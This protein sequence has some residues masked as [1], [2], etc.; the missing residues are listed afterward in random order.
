M[1]KPRFY[2]CMG[3]HTSGQAEAVG[4]EN[5][6]ELFLNSVTVDS[7]KTE[8]EDWICALV[9]NDTITPVK[10]DTGAQVNIL[11]KEDYRQLRDRTETLKGYNHSKI[12]VKGLCVVTVK[13]RGHKYKLEFFVV[14]ALALPLP[15]NNACE[16]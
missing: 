15:T 11:S 7:V 13:R 6:D 3:N 12:P 1:H 9:I 16:N 8:Q 2:S 14:P 10:L 4:E 5:S